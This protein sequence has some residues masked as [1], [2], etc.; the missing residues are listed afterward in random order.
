MT[1]PSDIETWPVC[2]FLITFFSSGFPMDKAIRYIK[3]RKPVCINDLP[4]QKVFWDRRLVLAILDAI[5]V[6]TPNRVEVNRDGGP[7]LDAEIVQEIESRLGIKLDLNRSAPEVDYSDPE[8]IKVDGKV[9]KKPFVE[10]PVSGEDHNINI[11]FGNGK[12]GRRLFRKVPMLLQDYVRGLIAIP[13]LA[14]NR[15]HWT[16]TSFTRAP[17]DRS[18][19]KNSSRPRT[20][21]TSRSTPSARTCTTPRP[22]NRRLSTE[23]SDGTRT[24][25][26]SAT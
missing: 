14:T 20:A 25:R 19:T 18:S 1:E 13:R 12:G 21:K 24:A 16:L 6:R 23:W 2:D 5:G 26:R 17:T 7:R 22:V 3:L 10:K 8:S 11:Y 4:L 15:R 9:L